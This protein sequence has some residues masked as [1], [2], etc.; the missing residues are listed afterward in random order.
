ME[1][2]DLGSRD[3]GGVEVE[4]RVVRCGTD[5]EDGTF[6]HVGEKDVLLRFVEAMDFIDKQDCAS[7]SA[8]GAVFGVEKCLAEIG[9]IIFDP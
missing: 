7:S 9:D 6:F 4:E 5:E 1:L 3:E 8:G 2:E